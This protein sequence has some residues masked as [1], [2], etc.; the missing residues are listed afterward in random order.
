MHCELAN[1]PHGTPHVLIRTGTSLHKTCS[2][3]GPSSA[4][5]ALK[6]MTSP[7][8]AQGC[9]PDM[10]AVVASVDQVPEP[11]LRLVGASRTLRLQR[12]L[13]SKLAATMDAKRIAV[14]RKPVVVAGRPEG[15]CRAVP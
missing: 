13:D 2:L 12:H 7:R 5:S 1:Q 3:H 15:R 11:E 10:I 14:G 9:A 8:M 4:E 6:V